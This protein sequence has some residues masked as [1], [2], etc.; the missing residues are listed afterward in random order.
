VA[1]VKNKFDK[2]TKQKIVTSLWLSLIAAGGAFIASI[3][4]TQNLKASAI[5]ALS[6]GGAFLV[7]TIRE[8]VKGESNVQPINPVDIQT[9][10]KV[11]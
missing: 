8:Y 2:E 10:S 7:N 1:Q 5:I 3:S 11:N 6:T 4:E 9:D